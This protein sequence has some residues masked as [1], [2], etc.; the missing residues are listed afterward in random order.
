MPEEGDIDE[1]GIHLIVEGPEHDIN[2]H[3]DSEEELLQ[4]MSIQEHTDEEEGEGE[5]EEEAVR[6]P[7][8]MGELM[9]LNHALKRPHHL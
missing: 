1:D 3:D 9:T 6:R 4:Q 8:R 5:D 2:P 7:H